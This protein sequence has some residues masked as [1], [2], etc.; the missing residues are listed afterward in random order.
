VT[1]DSA[2]VFHTPSGHFVAFDA[3]CTHRGCPTQYSSGGRLV[4]PCHSAVFDAATG[5]VLR[6]PAQ[7]GLRRISIHVVNG[8]IYTP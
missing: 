2:Y 4:C 1:S 6:G 3:T 8:E 5:A 7:V